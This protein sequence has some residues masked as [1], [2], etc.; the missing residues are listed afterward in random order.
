MMADSDSDDVAHDYESIDDYVPGSQRDRLIAALQMPRDVRTGAV[1]TTTGTLPRYGPSPVRQHSDG[2]NASSISSGGASRMYTS[3]PRQIAPPSF[4]ERPSTRPTPSSAPTT[5]SAIT[6]PLPKLTHSNTFSGGPPEVRRELKPPQRPPKK[7]TSIPERKDPIILSEQC[8]TLSGFCASQAMPKMVRVSAGHYGDCERTSISEGEEFVFYLVKTTLSVP[9]KPMGAVGNSERFYIPINSLLKVA[10][11]DKPSDAKRKYVY[12]TLSELLENRKELPTM[13]C[14]EREYYVK[15]KNLRLAAGTILF[16]ESKPTK[17]LFMPQFVTCRT[18]RNKEFDLPMDCGCG[19][20]THPADVQI[21]IGEY[22]TMVNKFPVDVQLYQGDSED[23]ED[24]NEANSSIGMSLT[25]DKPISQKSIIAKTDVEGTKKEHP[26]T[27]EIPFDLPIEVQAIARPDED[28]NQIYS[29]VMNLYQNF[30]QDT[31]EKSYSTAAESRLQQQLYKSVQHDYQP[32][33]APFQLDCPNTDYQPL[34]EVLNAREAYLKEQ[35]KNGAKSDEVD[36][37]K[38][39]KKQLEDEIAALQLAKQEYTTLVLPAQ[40][41][42]DSEDYTKLA[43]LDNLKELKALD[44]IGVCQLLEYMGLPQYVKKFREEQIDGELLS[45]LKEEDLAD[46]LVAS[47]LHRK[48]LM[49]IMTG[50]CSIRKYFD[51][52]NPYCTMVRN[53]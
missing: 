26:I 16:L 50:Q 24:S 12:A 8:F 34:Q 43:S 41:T 14:T 4:H 1:E 28:M 7:S 27:V 5:P 15:S 3:L 40:G 17:K 47:S 13:V 19:F 18:Q 44:V 49:L 51:T 46:L 36:R 9:A 11:I 38:E 20:S 45:E 37:L 52:E 2:N 33:E 21:H 39:E 32:M 53:K 31:V 48:R 10:V 42:T 22:L 23:G 29:E 30:S 35:E 25:L 6:S